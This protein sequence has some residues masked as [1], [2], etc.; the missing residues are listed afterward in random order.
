VIDGHGAT[1]SG[2]NVL[3]S[4]SAVGDGTFRHHWPHNLGNQADAWPNLSYN[5]ALLNREAMFVGGLPYHV[6]DSLNNLA[7]GTFFVDEGADKIIA[8]PRPGD[9][10]LASAE[11]TVRR[12]TLQIDGRSNVTVRNLTLERGAGGVQEV[13][14]GAWNSPNLTLENITVRQAAGCGLCVGGGMRAT[15]RNVRFLENGITGYGSYKQTGIVT[16]NA[17]LARTAGAGPR[18]ALP[19][20]Q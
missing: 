4:W 14:A 2:T 5:R 13:M 3:T 12:K 7:P 18:W 16:E 20:G 9:A 6:V 15:I 8:R 1:I 10:P 17:E 11:V 19:A